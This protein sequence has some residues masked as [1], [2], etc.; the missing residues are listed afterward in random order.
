MNFRGG[1]HRRSDIWRDR[2]DH[3][4]A[5]LA[6]AAVDPR[7]VLG[8]L[9]ENNLFLATDN[10]GASWLKFPSVL[11]L[12]AVALSGA[13]YPLIQNWHRGKKKNTNETTER[14]PVS[15]WAPIFDLFVVVMFVWAL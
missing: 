6:A 7:L 5:R 11:L 10:Y 14:E 1:P 13:C 2:M 3:G 9:T 12:F 4:P 8:P 15:L